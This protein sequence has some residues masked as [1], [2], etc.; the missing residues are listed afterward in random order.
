[1]VT[2]F[3]GSSH[4]AFRS[5][6]SAR[7]AWLQGPTAGAGNWRPP[8]PR[9]A[10]PTPVDART[11]PPSSGSQTSPEGEEFEWGLH[12]SR[13]VAVPDLGHA[14]SSSDVE[15]SDDET[16]H[17]HGD[18]D[19]EELYWRDYDDPYAQRDTDLLS[20]TISSVSSLSLSPSPSLTA[21]T[22]SP[23]PVATPSLSVGAVSPHSTPRIRPRALPV[24]EVFVAS[25]PMS[26]PGFRSRAPISSPPRPRPQPVSASPAPRVRRSSPSS[27]KSSARGSKDK[28]A[29][30]VAAVPRPKEF[31]VVI[32]GEHPGIY[33]DK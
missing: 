15:H 12:L 5:L 14:G 7:R 22:I 13:D 9:P 23:G 1:M 19:D 17:R 2:G 11:V 20:S 21:G 8:P 18:D 6:A 4:K 24:P 16:G 29:V 33:M 31:F 26:S 3:S 32:R 27:S 28:P 10:I 30:E 25:P